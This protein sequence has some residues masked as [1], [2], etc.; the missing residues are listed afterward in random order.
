MKRLLAIALAVAACSGS[1]TEPAPTISP[2]AVAVPSPTDATVRPSVPALTPSAA[3]AAA[4]ETPAASRKLTAALVA[5]VKSILTASL[6]HYETE[7]AAGK[8]ALGTKPYPDAF[9]GLQAMNDPNSTA[10]KF[11]TWRTSTQVEQDLSFL[12]AFTQADAYYNADNEP[13]AIAAWRDDM[14]DATAALNE[15]I[16]VGV[17]WQISEKTSAELSGAQAAVTAGF[18]QV[19]KDID[20]TVAASR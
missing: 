3:E 8:V 10:A 5:S 20:A 13:E 1:A 14:S 19:Q 11:S 4:S 7:Y 12:D 17:G 6:M 16:Q 15:W 18:A 2:P 9:A